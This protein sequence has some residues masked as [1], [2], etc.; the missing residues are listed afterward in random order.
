MAGADGAI[1]GSAI[2]DLIEKNIEKKARI[3]NEVSNFVKELKY[4]PKQKALK[5]RV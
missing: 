2:V 3:L 4:N 1:V 5:R